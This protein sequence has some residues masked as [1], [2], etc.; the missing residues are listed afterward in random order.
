MA[1]DSKYREDFNKNYLPS[2]TEYFSQAQLDKTISSYKYLIEDLKKIE[3]VSSDS[4]YKH[5]MS[6]KIYSFQK[7]LK[8]YVVVEFN[9]NIC[10]ISF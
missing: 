2:F 9:I 3:K 5:V 10:E 8:I 1:D 7:M 6:K 4:T